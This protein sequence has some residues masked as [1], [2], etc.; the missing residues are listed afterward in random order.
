MK[1]SSNVFIQKKKKIY[2]YDST[3]TFNIV[4]TYL[5]FFNKKREKK[6]EDLM[7]P[8]PCEL[9]VTMFMEKKWY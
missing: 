8:N 6:K 9:S 1:N 7:D 5:R 3:F 4:H 2:P